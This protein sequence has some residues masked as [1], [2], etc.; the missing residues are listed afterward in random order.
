MKLCN[1]NETI[2][3]RKRK[4]VTLYDC[5]CAHDGSHWL[6]MCDPHA[7]AH[8]ELHASARITHE[9]DAVAVAA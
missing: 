7:F 4:G 2:I 5:K 9:R 1:G 8:D 6:Q 3:E